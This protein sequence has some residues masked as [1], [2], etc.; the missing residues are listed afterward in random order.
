MSSIDEYPVGKQETI[1]APCPS[2]IRLHTDDLDVYEYAKIQTFKQVKSEQGKSGFRS[3]LIPGV[4]KK[5]R[6]I[7]F[8]VQNHRASS[9]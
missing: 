7:Q 8:S 5:H 1:S 3:P 2:S 6:L 4:S 9:P